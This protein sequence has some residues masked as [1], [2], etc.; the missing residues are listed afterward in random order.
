MVQRPQGD[1]LMRR[2]ASDRVAKVMEMVGMEEDM[3]LESSMVSR[4][5]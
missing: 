2:F 1:S 3:P 5:I 4:F